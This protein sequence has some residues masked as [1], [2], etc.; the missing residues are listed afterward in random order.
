MA[1]IVNQ[2]NI[3]V[4]GAGQMFELLTPP[5]LVKVNFMGGEEFANVCSE[6]VRRIQPELHTSLL[7]QYTIAMEDIV[8][9]LNI[10]VDIP[11]RMLER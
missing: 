3:N 9:Q 8:N 4:D 6:S 1:A 11:G 10:N 7:L 2:L 5:S